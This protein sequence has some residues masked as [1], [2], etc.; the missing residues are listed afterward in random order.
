MSEEESVRRLAE[1]KAYL[2]KRMLEIQDEASKLKSLL[3]VVDASLA[4]K[5]FRKMEVPKPAAPAPPMPQEEEGLRQVVPLKTPEG[6]H[7]ADSSETESDLIVTPAPGM[8]FDVS[9]PPLR[10]FLIGR[11]LEPMRSRDE[12]SARA[13]EMSPEGTLSYTFEQDGNLMKRLVIKN[14]GDERRLQELRNAIRWTLRRM[15]ERTL[16]GTRPSA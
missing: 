9:S 15:Y 3:E 4:E 10:A 14:Y 12:A 6:V 5:S 8:K 1:V 7:L 11:V 16:V 2:E 13:G